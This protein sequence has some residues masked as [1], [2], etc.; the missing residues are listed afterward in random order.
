MRVSFFGKGGSGKTTVS[1]SF[2]KYLLNKKENVLAID[3]DMNVHLGKVFDMPINIISEQNEEITKFL[4][5]NRNIPIIGT[6]PPIKTSKFIKVSKDEPFIKKYATIKNNL[7]LFTVGTYTEDSVGSDCYH[8]KLN[9]L[10]LI[11]HR[12]LDTDKDYV[13]N[14][15]TAG[16]D[17]LGTSLFFVSD[18]N[19]FVVE[20]TLKGIS[21]YKDF[22]NITDTLGIKTY[23]IGNKIIDDED[24]E[25]LIKEIGEKNILGFIKSSKNLKKYEQGHKE[26]F[27][28]FVNENKEVYENIIAVMKNTPRD[29]KKYYERLKKVYIAACLDWYSEYYKDDLTK[30]IDQTFSYEELEV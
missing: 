3:A 19:I 23:V 9:T 27:D 6:T 17:S 28:E 10:E 2:I 8:S 29:W 7:M 30:Y 4:E 22:K 1:S 24:K 12:L 11:Y 25:F 13:I 14:D 21:V 20:P 18:I 16:I 5:P 15:S 26:Y